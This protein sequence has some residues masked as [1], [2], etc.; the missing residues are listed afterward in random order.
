MICVWYASIRACIQFIPGYPMLNFM[1][2]TLI[3]V[4][5]ANR[6]FLLTGQLKNAMMPSKVCH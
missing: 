2:V 6:L 3:Y 5:I 4:G 1:V